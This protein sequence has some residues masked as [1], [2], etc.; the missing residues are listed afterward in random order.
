[1]LSCNLNSMLERCPSVCY[2]RTHYLS[3]VKTSA[4]NWE[5]T[6]LLANEC[7][8]HCSF[9]CGNLLP[10]GWIWR[11]AGRL[12]WN[13]CGRCME[14]NGSFS[15]IYRCKH[16]RCTTIT[17]VVRSGMATLYVCLIFVNN[18]TTFFSVLFSALC[19]GTCMYLMACF[20]MRTILLFLSSSSI[21][22]QAPSQFTKSY[23]YLL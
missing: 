15:S 3:P 9:H 11:K 16:S 10:S 18:W 13:Q 4:L 20:W 19:G 12:E 23:V 1:M 14:Y 6:S 2:V 8:F 17:P 5:F 7:N 21:E 22:T